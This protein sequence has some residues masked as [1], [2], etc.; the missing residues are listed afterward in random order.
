MKLAVRDLDLVV[1]AL[2]LEP[3]LLGRD[4]VELR[5]WLKELRFGLEETSARLTDHTDRCERGRPTDVT[6]RTSVART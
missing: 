6:C 4:H 1:L 2:L 5:F 3:L